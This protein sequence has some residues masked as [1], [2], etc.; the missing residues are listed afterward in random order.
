MSP[1]SFEGSSFKAAVLDGRVVGAPPAGVRDAQP[2]HSA[3]AHL[4]EQRPDPGCHDCSCDCDDIGP[5]PCETQM[6][7]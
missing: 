4:T 2:M 3:A 6:G 5:C 7:S 1:A